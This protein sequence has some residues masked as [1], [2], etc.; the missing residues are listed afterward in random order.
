MSEHHFIGEPTARVSRSLLFSVAVL[1]ASLAACAGMYLIWISDAVSIDRPLGFAVVIG[2]YLSICTLF[3]VLHRRRVR[4]AETEPP[5]DA[6]TPNDLDSLDEVADYFTGSLTSDDAFRFVADRVKA[7]T[8]YDSIVLFLLDQTRTG[9][10]ASHAEGISADRHKGH[11]LGLDEGL[12]GQAFS[13]R[14]VEVDSYLALDGSDEFGSAAAIPLKRGDNVF[15]VLQL[16]FATSEPVSEG[17]YELFASIGSR[18]EPL[19]L[20]SISFERSQAN[21]L[22]DLTT[23][24]PNERAFYLKLEDQVA[25]AQRNKETRPLSV[26]AIDIKNFEELSCTFGH[27]AGDRLLAFVASVIKENVRQMD[28][29]ARALNDEFLVILP[30]ADRAMT[31]EI[32]TRINTGFAGERFAINESQAVEVA[33]NVGW[34]SFGSDGETPGQLL[35]LAQLRKEQLKFS[36]PSNV[37]FFPV[38]TRSALP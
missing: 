26:L 24:L 38:E 20:G 16:Y 31:H 6:P 7:V 23:D 28:F 17:V 3:F 22:T 32:I 18:I 30:T 11:R 36:S 10:V 12:A 25:E 21:A 14:Q 35:S 5:A 8:N 15:G 13:T 1:M 9:L 37:L 2:L 4:T 29:V 27:A 33:L 19:I 34:S